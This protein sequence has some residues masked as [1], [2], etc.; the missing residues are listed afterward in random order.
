MRIFKDKND[1]PVHLSSIHGRDA[2]EGM[3]EGTPSLVRKMRLRRAN[4]DMKN[5]GV[6]YSGIEQIERELKDTS[7]EDLP[8]PPQEHWQAQV[9]SSDY[10]GNFGDIYRYEKKQ[11]IIHWYAEGGDPMQHLGQIIESID[12]LSLCKTL[13][14]DSYD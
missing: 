13:I 2:F 10:L 7:G 14:E 9:G 12:F 11:L 5:E 1:Y 3:I 8:W 6:Y 4:E